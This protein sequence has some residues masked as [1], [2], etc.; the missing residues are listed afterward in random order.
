MNS[1]QVILD[2]IEARQHFLVLLQPGSLSQ[3]G[4]DGD[5]LRREITHALTHRR[6][7]VPVTADGFELSHDLAL[8]HDISKL[9]S[10]NAVPIPPGYTDE[11]MD[12]LRTRFLKMPSNR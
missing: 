3:I 10:F 9:P 12:R 4:K 6:N 1:K 5:W 2:Q 8:P 7:V 11:A